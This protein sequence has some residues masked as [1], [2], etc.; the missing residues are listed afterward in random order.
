MTLATFLTKDP[1]MRK[2]HL[3]KTEMGFLYTS[4]DVVF[5]QIRRI[6]AL[7]Q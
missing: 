3:V 7:I 6:H 1:L 2:T 4:I 5:F